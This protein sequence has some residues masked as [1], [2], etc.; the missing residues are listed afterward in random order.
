MYFIGKNNSPPPPNVTT[1]TIDAA[2]SHFVDDMFDVLKRGDFD[3]VQ[4]KC[5]E[6]INVIG[7][8]KLSTKV[9][10]RIDDSKNLSGLFKVLC[11]CRS[12]WNWMNI[13]M[14]EKLAGNSLEANQLIENY[15]N[16]VFSRKVKDVMSDICNLEVP[17]DGYTEVMEKW[18]KDFND[19]TV[20]DIVERWGDI[21]KRFNVEETMLLKSIEEGCVEICWL[22]PDHLSKDTVT[23]VTNSQH[24]LG[25]DNQEKVFSE[26]L[27][28]KIGDV[29]I[30]D[31]V[32]SKLC[33]KCSVNVYH[34]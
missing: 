11:R 34:K 32:M 5:L 17:T 4:R 10:E 28:L 3:K 33:L 26:M 13:R 1:A 2:F 7:G 24:Q 23:L 16:K 12:H 15:K 22:L 8:I 29:I 20:T 6:N 21:E 18:N 31:D 14:L 30:K 9:E 19:L 25:T 27:Y